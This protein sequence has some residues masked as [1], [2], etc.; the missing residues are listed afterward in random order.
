MA[1]HA[2][3][4]SGL[5]AILKVNT[6]RVILLQELDDVWSE[7]LRDVDSVKTAVGVRAFANLSPED[8]FR[9]EASKAS[10]QPCFMHS[11]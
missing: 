11:S 4:G 2:H 10:L 9:L 8:E 1:V 7:F 6:L 5:S 3:I